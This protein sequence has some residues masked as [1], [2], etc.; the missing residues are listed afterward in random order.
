MTEGQGCIVQLAALGLLPE[1]VRFV[2]PSHLHS[3]HT[4]AIG[5]FPNATHV[6]WRREYE[7]AFSPDW[8]AAAAYAR[9][10]FDGPGLKWQFLEGDVAD[11]YDLYGGGVLRTVYAPGHTLGD[12]S[13]IVTLHNSGAIL[14]A[15]DAVYTMDHWNEKALPGFVASAVESVW[16]VRKLRAPVVQFQH[17]H[18]V[19]ASTFAN[20]SFRTT[21]KY[22]ILVGIWI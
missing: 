7:Y 8:F 3:D 12:Q 19:A 17:S 4:S 2:V 22:M 18:P 13:L 9:K 5:R 14:L 16:S 15:A 1:D 20:V 6:V 11:N 21:S 10:N